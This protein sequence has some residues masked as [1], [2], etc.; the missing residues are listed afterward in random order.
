MKRSWIQDLYSLVPTIDYLLFFKVFFF[1][2]YPIHL[3][4]LSVL[5]DEHGVKLLSGGVKNIFLMCR[6]KCVC[7]YIYIYKVG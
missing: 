7:A 1:Q 2:K 4:V 5:L 6:V 3:G